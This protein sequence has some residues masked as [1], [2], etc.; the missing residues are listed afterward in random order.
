MRF[1]PAPWLLIAAGLLLVC[2]SLI[3]AAGTPPAIF[4]PADRPIGHRG[5]AELAAPRQ[6]LRPL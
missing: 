2:S 3:L 1:R 4:R 5:Q 6:H